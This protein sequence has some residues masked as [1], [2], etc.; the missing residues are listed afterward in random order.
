MPSTEVSI[1]QSQ[2]C[3]RDSRIVVLVNFKVS[4]RRGH[5]G[6]VKVGV[7]LVLTVVFD[8]NIAKYSRA[9]RSPRSKNVLAVFLHIDVFLFQDGTVVI[10]NGKGAGGGG[11][12]NGDAAVVIDFVGAAGRRD[13]G[14]AAFL[15]QKRKLI[16][17]SG[18]CL[19]YT[20]R[21]V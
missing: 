2:M 20:S 13:G 8:Q 6:L 10:N 4:R 9:G 11:Q 3:I 17:R 18:S 19:L 14:V 5:T 12:R 16:R 7:V 1:G 15:R 21:C